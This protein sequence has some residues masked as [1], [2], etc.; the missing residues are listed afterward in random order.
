MALLFVFYSNQKASVNHSTEFP[1]QRGVKQGDTLSAILF[2][3]VLDMAFDMWRISLTHEGIILAHGVP[4]LTNIRY[5]DD[6]LLYAKS[7]QELESMTERLLDALKAI[8]LLLNVKKAHIL[9]CNA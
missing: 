1:V 8:I 2:N 5:A 9:R 7:L 4:R 6:V 3:C